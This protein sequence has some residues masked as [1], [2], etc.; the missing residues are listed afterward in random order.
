MFSKNEMVGKYQIIDRLGV[1]GFGTVYLARDCL[2]NREVA[3]KVPHEQGDEMGEIMA[4]LNN[5]AAGN[6]AGGLHPKLRE[7]VIMAQL[8]HQNIVQLI[9]VE[10]NN[11]SL[12]MVME[13]VRGESLDK[14]IRRERGIKPQR[15]L[16]IAIGVCSAIAFAH[17]SQVIHR[18]LRPANILMTSDGLPK[19]TDFGTSRIL[20][21]H[22]EQYARTRIGSPP[23]MAPEHFQ[24]KA[25]LQSDLWS[26]GITIYEMLTGKVPFY[27]ID[28]LEIAKFFSSAKDFSPP[29][30]CNPQVPRH[31]SDVVMKC[32]KVKLGDRYISAQELLRDL[33]GLKDLFRRDTRP[34]PNL[35][36]VQAAPLANPQGGQ[37]GHQRLCRFCYKPMPRM[38]TV[39]PICREKN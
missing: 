8:K 18:D 39:C 22:R 37:G 12:F 23:Y 10:G 3:L 28:P 35:P 27:D 15:A 14:L 36:P 5:P 24:G 38:A 25:V 17:S 20:D 4:A 19:V 26:I 16:D 11:G 29:H 7:A 9:T 31:F 32:L 30:I 1:G 33:N 13:Y 34:M 21:M 6:Q 2:L